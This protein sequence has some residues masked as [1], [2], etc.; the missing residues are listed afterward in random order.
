LST[1]AVI[2]EAADLVDHAGFEALSL[3]SVARRLGVRPPSLYVHIGSLDHLR[4]ELR[5]R[6]LR[7]LVDEIR[8]RATGVSGSEAIAQMC[9][10]F[11][12]VATERPGLYAATVPAVKE[13]RDD[14]AV[15]AEEVLGVAVAVLRG[16]GVPDDQLV[17]AARF[18]RS[19]THGFISLEAAGGFGLPVDLDRSFDGL[20]GA[21][22]RGVEEY[23]A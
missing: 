14:V 11:R 19:A 17:H 23:A 13:D 16:A 12:A 8:R 7:L 9:R 6:G 3:A 1:E 22:V 5:L 21:V 10:A 15:A 18:V 20:V 2:D 4:C